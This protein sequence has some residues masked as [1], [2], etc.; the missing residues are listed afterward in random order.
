MRGIFFAAIAPGKSQDAAFN[1]LSRVA[2]SKLLQPFP[3]LLCIPHCRGVLHGM[4]PRSIQLTTFLHFKTTAFHPH[5]MKPLQHSCLALAVLSACL[6]FA[7]RADNPP[8]YVDFGKLP[9]AAAGGETVEVNI[10]SGLI[11]IAAKLAEKSEPDVAELLRGLHGVRVNV[12]G[13]SDENRAD[14]EN[15]IKSVRTTLDGQGWQRVVN[16]QNKGEDVGVYVKTRGDEAI[17]GIVVTVLNA[18]HEAVFVNVVG[19][20]KPEKIAKLADEFD[21]EPLKK[22]AEAIEKQKN[23]QKE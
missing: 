7:A 18:G 5:P 23:K 3:R 15:R 11:S 13:V 14:I 2:P 6:T 19:D 4:Q 1:L 20:I 21:I 10:T 16:V 17:E 22:A 12:I 8:G 9:A